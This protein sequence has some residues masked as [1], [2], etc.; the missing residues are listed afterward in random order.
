M[1]EYIKEYKDKE[2]GDEKKGVT[3][4]GLDL[5]TFNSF[6][7]FYAIAGNEKKFFEVFR[8]EMQEEVCSSPKYVFI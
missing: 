5:E 6:L 2:E 7:D 8:E 4:V 1:K 3:K